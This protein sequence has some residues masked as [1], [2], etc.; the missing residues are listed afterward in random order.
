M[1]ENTTV[2]SNK[3][4]NLVDQK[5]F[6]A[7]NILATSEE[8]SLY[9]PAA[10]EIAFTFGAEKTLF[11]TGD[12]IDHSKL[13]ESFRKNLQLLIQKTWVEK[14]DIELKEKVL[15]ELNQFHNVLM[16]HD[17]EKSYNLFLP[18]LDNVVYLMFGTQTKQEDFPEY[19]MRIDPDFGTFW[20]Y[21]QTLNPDSTP[22]KDKC[23]IS[24]LLALY[25]LANY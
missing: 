19:A 25:F 12:P 9:I 18:L 16:A 17:W 6:N 20:L 14:S 22:S 3:Y 8:K 7:L 23:R 15:F 21:I 1:A 10:N 11:S 4:E 13:I 24:V 5:I 2:I